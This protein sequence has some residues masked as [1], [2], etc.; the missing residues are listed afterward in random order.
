MKPEVNQSACFQTEE[1]SKQDSFSA[2][3]FKKGEKVELWQ[4]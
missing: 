3:E 2:S 4:E 1:E